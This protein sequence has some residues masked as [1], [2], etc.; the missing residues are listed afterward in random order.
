MFCISNF[1]LS[2]VL[3]KK[4]QLFE[5]Y[6]TLKCILFRNNPWCSPS[7]TRS[8]TI[9]SLNQVWLKS[10]FMKLSKVVSFIFAFW[11]TTDFE[12]EKF[13]R[14]ERC[15][16]LTVSTCGWVENWGSWVWLIKWMKVLKVFSQQR[17]SKFSK[18]RSLQSHEQR[19]GFWLIWL[20]LGKGGGKVKR[21]RWMIQ[22]NQILVFD[23]CIIWF[24][25][26]LFTQYPCLKDMFQSG[27]VHPASTY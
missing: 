12:N 2:S 17:G 21:S 23:Y 11:I 19:K 20:I 18:G 6:S 24:H 14:A 1:L 16:I 10:N 9:I 8:W 22:R 15:S 26:T 3:I 25:W 13:K 7:T 4:E 27:K 5:K